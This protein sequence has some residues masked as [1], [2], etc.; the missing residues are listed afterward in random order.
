MISAVIFA[1]VAI[2]QHHA[3]IFG[4]G[5]DESGDFAANALQIEGARQFRELHGNYSRWGFNHPGPAFFYVYAVGEQ[6]LNRWMG[7]V[8]SPHQA[9]IIAGILLQACFLGAGV[10]SVSI[11]SGH[12]LPILLCAVVILHFAIAGRSLA[13]IWMPNALLGPTFALYPLAACVALGHIGLLPVLVITCGFLVSAHVAQP[14]FVIPVAAAAITLL[15][16]RV[17][18][19][20]KSDGLLAPVLTSA[21]VMLLFV[22]PLIID[23]IRLNESNVAHILSFLLDDSND[24]KHWWQ[25]LIYISSFFIYYPAP[26]ATIKTLTFD[27]AANISLHAWLVVVL[28]VIAILV[29]YLKAGEQHKGLS[30]LGFFVLLG[31]LLCIPWGM[32]QSGEMYAFNSFFIYSLIVLAITPWALS[33]E[34]VGRGATG[35]LWLTFPAALVLLAHSASAPLDSAEQGYIGLSRR[36]NELLTEKGRPSNIKLSFDH[37]DWPR[38]TAVALA[39][40]R[41]GVSVQVDQGWGFMFGRSREVPD[42][43]SQT[44]LNWLVQSGK[45]KSPSS[46]EVIPQS[47]LYIHIDTSEEV[48]A[49]PAVNINTP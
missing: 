32:M 21:G 19:S 43:H 29:S 46:I 9:H 6:V 39:L 17:K 20:Q 36:L 3:F 48:P 8:E 34:T 12:K 42:A 2:W 49:T 45:T 40:L 18:S 11:L 24:R 13:C 41:S 27:T 30:Y 22:L 15:S 4:P 47:D 14:L 31:F 5:V 1:V 25:A 23:L 33:F 38:A 37:A 28:S 10:A 35:R 26:E 16:I 7:L 44:Q